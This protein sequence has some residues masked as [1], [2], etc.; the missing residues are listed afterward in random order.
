MPLIVDKRFLPKNTTAGSR[1]K[2]V[3]R[4]RE[5]IK[6]RVREHVG[7]NSIKDYNAGDKKIKIK[8]DDLDQ[9]NFEFEP[10]TGSQDR[11]L[12]GNKKFVKGQKLGKPRGGQGGS[13][14]TKGGNGSGGKDDFEFILTEEEFANL[15]FEDLA[16]PDLLKKQFVS[17]SYEIKPAGYSKSG[18][19]A[20]LNVKRTILNSIGRR[21]IRRKK[22]ELLEE[23]KD[24]ETSYDLAT[25]EEVIIVPKKKI[26][27]IEDMDLRYN[28]RDKQEIPTTKAVMF[29]LMDVSGSMGEVEKDMAKRFYILLYMFLQRVYSKVD[30][31]FVRHTETAEE[32]DEKTFFY[33][34]ESGGTIISSGYELIHEIINKRYNSD[35]WNIYVAQASDGD[36]YDNDNEQMQQILVDKLLPLTQYFAYINVGSNVDNDVMNILTRLMSSHKNLQARVVRD[37]TQIFEVFRS[38]FKKKDI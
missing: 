31:V 13:G 28:F 9:P 35:N 30:V 15:F 22:E 23:L 26:Q 37:Y 16:L 7:K 24:T 2:F 8:I 38:L 21:F 19:P 11:I 17:E 6:K 20:S 4:Y 33:D 18:G 25:G 34:R 29:L 27:F 5:A 3:D 14:G 1:Q 36:N 10:D 12:I 32:V